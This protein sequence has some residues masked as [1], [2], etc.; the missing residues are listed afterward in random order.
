MLNHIYGTIQQE[1][2]VT[3]YHQTQLTAQANRPTGF[4]SFDSDGFTL[5]T[6]SGGVVNDSSRGPYVAWCWK[7]GGGTTSSNTE[8]TITSTVQANT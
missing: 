3:I 6:D 4:T 1:A 8:G 7:A 2:Q 5:G